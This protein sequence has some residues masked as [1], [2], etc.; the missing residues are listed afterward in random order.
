[1]QVKNIEIETTS[2]LCE[3]AENTENDLSTISNDEASESDPWCSSATHSATENEENGIKIKKKINK[4]YVGLRKNK[5]VQDNKN[6]YID[7]LRSEKK[8]LAPCQCH[9]K[10]VR[11]NQVT[12]E[13]RES[14]FRKFW[15]LS[16]ECKRFYV[17]QRMEMYDIQRP[18]N[19]KEDGISCRSHTFKY[20]F[21]YDGKV[22]SVCQKM[23]VNTLDVPAWTMQSWKQHRRNKTI[24]RIGTL[25]DPR[26]KTQKCFGSNANYKAAKT[27]FYSLFP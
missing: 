17:C 20:S 2:K 9:L 15:E 21:E 5:N 3:D 14:I 26:F 6:E 12:E 27:G 23:F 10:N 4:D 25:I 1:M 7:V 11:C 22:Y 8:L 16:W 19:R 24:P 13:M 18:C